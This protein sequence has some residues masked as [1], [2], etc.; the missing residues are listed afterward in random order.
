MA[1]A[2]VAAAASS[3]LLPYLAG[4][5]GSL[6]SSIT[7]GSVVSA[8]VSALKFANE[9]G[10]L[11][12]GVSSLLGNTSQWLRS[13]GSKRLRRASEG[14]RAVE[15]APQRRAVEDAP[16][17]EAPQQAD[18]E[19]DSISS[20]G[21]SNNAESPEGQ[22]GTGVARAQP[23]PRCGLPMLDGEMSFKQRV[24]LILPS[25]HQRKTLTGDIFNKYG[26]VLT[27]KWAV[28]FMNSGLYLTYKEALWCRTVYTH[29]Q[30]ATAA[31][32]LS[33]FQCHSVTATG[34][35]A[36]GFSMSSS[37]VFWKSLQMNST[38]AGILW[39]IGD[40]DL[41][42]TEGTGPHMVVP[43]NFGSARPPLLV[44]D[45]PTGNEGATNTAV[46][47]Q[48]SFWWW[49]TPSSFNKQN[50]IIFIEP[51]WDRMLD[52]QMG[53]PIHDA[54]V[55]IQTTDRDWR[56]MRTGV[57]NGAET[58]RSPPV[59][60]A[61]NSDM[62]YMRPQLQPNT[63]PNTFSMT[64]GFHGNCGPPTWVGIWEDI[65]P[66]NDMPGSYFSGHPL[67]C[68]QGYKSDTVDAT[69]L[70]RTE[71]PFAPAG[72]DKKKV[73]YGSFRN[74]YNQ[75]GAKSQH[76]DLWLL[77]YELPVAPN[78][79]EMPMVV[80]CVVETEINVRL[81][82]VTFT[83]PLINGTMYKVSTAANATDPGNWEPPTAV[84]VLQYATPP[85]ITYRNTRNA[86]S[87]RSVAGATAATLSSMPQAAINW[88]LPLHKDPWFDTAHTQTQVYGNDILG[89]GDEMWNFVRGCGLQTGNDINRTTAWQL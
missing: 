53:S 7:G 23:L 58:G 52:M 48:W 22:L 36:P 69:N 85:E 33:N 19:M 59:M 49:P 39:S 24:R 20:L 87:I 67:V 55:F 34:Q 32:K 10:L 76:S 84:G 26:Y 40:S 86:T 27:G 8:G 47:N 82:N 15:P 17:E 81:R 79:M 5:G 88:H 71:Y 83:D 56:T 77:D 6:V 21:N 74:A 18:A 63:Y 25:D 44:S 68:Q 12:G 61:A 72:A 51:D 78:Q 38:E 30:Y 65:K 43:M 46:I 37:G 28:P 66:K 45:N 54:A 57:P 9:S 41:S 14:D 73:P 42:G 64:P 80:S 35:N 3:S 2:P 31:V 13:P 4:A 16:A 11:A 50:E 29:W 75:Q 89:T 62:P 60:D 70:Y 1:L